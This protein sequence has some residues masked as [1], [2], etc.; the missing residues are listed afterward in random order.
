MLFNLWRCMNGICSKDKTLEVED[1]RYFDTY[2][3]GKTIVNINLIV[4][5]AITPYNL[6]STN[7]FSGKY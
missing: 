2:L 5:S 4:C 6:L 7:H 1:F 3:D